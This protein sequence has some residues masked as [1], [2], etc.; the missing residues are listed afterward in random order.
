MAKIIDKHLGN[1]TGKLGNVIFR[2]TPSGKYSAYTIQKKRK[3]PLSKEFYEN[4]SRFALINKFSSAVSSLYFT[5]KTW[6]VKI[7]RNRPL[8]RTLIFKRNF[9]YCYPDVI[10]PSAVISPDDVH[11]PVIAFAHDK[12][13]VEIT[14]KSD[15]Y[16]KKSGNNNFVAGVMIYLNA[17]ILKKKSGK[18]LKNNL[19]ITFERKINSIVFNR[20]NTFSLKFNRGM[21]EFGVIDVYQRVRVYC[22]ITFL[23]K[24]DDF[25]WT[26]SDSFL[27]KGH[28]L[29]EMSFGMDYDTSKVERKGINLD[30]ID[31]NYNTFKI[32]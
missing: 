25:R 15:Q 8:P 5:K 30:N 17:P 29:D 22:C 4:N 6:N 28:E 7:G 11:C 13:N 9:I 2:R 16:F 31:L 19:F 21:G 26:H 18:N 27:Y 12:D 3:K 32:L 20:D 23:N 1:I 24:D 10:G 14:L